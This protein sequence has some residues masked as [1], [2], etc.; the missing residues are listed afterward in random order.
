MRGN[1]TVKGA[2]LEQNTKGAQKKAERKIKNP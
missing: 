1:E 2:V